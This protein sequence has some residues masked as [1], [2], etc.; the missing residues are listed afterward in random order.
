MC[1]ELGKIACIN[2]FVLN[3]EHCDAPVV[4][5]LVQVYTFLIRLLDLDYL[6]VIV[7]YRFCFDSFILRYH[8]FHK[9]NVSE[10]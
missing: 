6:H 3:F 10:M 1:V 7:M 2:L 9:S 4:I 5:S 8:N